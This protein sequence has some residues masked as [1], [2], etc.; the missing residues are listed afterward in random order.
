MDKL[1]ALGVAFAY[2]LAGV[3]NP[4]ADASDQMI[5]LLVAGCALGLLGGMAAGLLPMGR[6]PK[7]GWS[8]ALWALALGGLSGALASLFFH[9]FFPGLSNEAQWFLIAIAGFAAQKILDQIAAASAGTMWVWFLR[10]FAPMPPVD[11]APPAPPP[12]PPATG[13]EG[14]L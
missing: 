8:N 12:P 7:W 11:P 2:M 9:G 4:L 13:E 1:G 5:S 6:N 14:H 3:T 10:K